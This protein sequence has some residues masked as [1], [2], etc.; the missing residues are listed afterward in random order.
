MSE[1][2]LTQ[3][4]NQKYINLQTFK[5]DGTPVATPVWFAEDGGELYVYTLANSGKMKR[6]RNNR[7]VR[8][9]VSDA[10]GKLKGEWVDAEARLLD[11]AESTKGHRRITEKYGLIKRI[12]DFF[13]KFRKQQRAVFAIRVR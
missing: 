2:K 1:D 8:I 5:K 13:S 7:R 6:L 9:A 10:R 11:E 3:F 4:A 12:L